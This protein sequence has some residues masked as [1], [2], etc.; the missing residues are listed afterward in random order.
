MSQIEVHDDKQE[1]IVD[2]ALKRFAHFGPSK[3]TM[4]E[5]ADDLRLSKA[6]IYYYF[7]DKASL[8]KA[9]LEKI[10]NTYFLEI[11]CEANHSK[12]VEKALFNLIAVRH[13]FFM[14]FFY[15][16]GLNRNFLEGNK[17]SLD[18]I[19]ATAIKREKKFVAALLE[20]A[21]Q[22]GELKVTNPEEQADLYIDLLKGIR[23]SFITPGTCSQILDEALLKEINRKSRLLTE[24]FVNAHKNSN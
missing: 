17:N 2:A 11:E 9:V 19:A 14:K 24:L 12:T 8:L 16:M 4:N 3:T 5:I 18:E 22:T 15:N 23:F 7:P 1:L 13:D 20:R 6:L 10:L 21:N